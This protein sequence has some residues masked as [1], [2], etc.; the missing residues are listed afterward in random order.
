[1]PSRLVIGASF[2]DHLFA[3]VPAFVFKAFVLSKVT[4]C[5]HKGG[6]G[7]QNG[8]VA[9]LHIIKMPGRPQNGSKMRWKLGYHTGMRICWAVLLV[10]CLALGCKKA[11][12]D[13]VGASKT[14]PVASATPAGGGGSGDSVNPMPTPAGG[15]SPVT[16]GENLGGTGGGA[17]FAAK[18]MARRTANKA[19][20]SSLSQGDT[21]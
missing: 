9:Q 3:V 8:D 17:G 20:S 1:M 12:T 7:K 2:F 6:Q 21:D 5:Q 14:S 4:T 18:D 10:C 15:A 16:G 19:S 13:M 11:D